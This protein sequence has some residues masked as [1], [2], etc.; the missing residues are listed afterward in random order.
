MKNGVF[1][2]ITVCGSCKSR[3]SGGT[4]RLHHHGEKNQ[5]TSNVSSNSE[6]SVIT[7]AI[8]RDIP[9]DDILHSDLALTGWTL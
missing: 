1:W 4:H 8:L 6:T 7:K 5:R 3:C 2:D 9:E